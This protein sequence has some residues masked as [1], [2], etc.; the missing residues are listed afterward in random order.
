[1]MHP[2]IGSEPP[3]NCWQV[4]MRT[5]MKGGIMQAPDRSLGP[6]RLLE[7]ML[8]EEEPNVDGSCEQRDRHMDK[9]KRSD[10]HEEYHHHDYQGDGCVGGHRTD[11]ETPVAAEA[12]VPRCSSPPCVIEKAEE[13]AADESRCRKASH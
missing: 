8:N 2:D 9:K 7:L 12:K 4:I 11:P 3:Q 10:T 6:P 13:E 1:M 5:A